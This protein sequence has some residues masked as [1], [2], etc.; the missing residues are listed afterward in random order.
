METEPQLRPKLLQPIQPESGRTRQASG[1]IPDGCV[2]CLDS[3][4]EQAV[5]LP[6]KHCSFDFLCLV[7]WLEERSVC[8]LC[9]TEVRAIN[10]GWSSSYGCKTYRLPRSARRAA[11]T[12]PRG[13]ERSRTVSN[14]GRP[15]HPNQRLRSHAR[16]LP[17]PKSGAPLLNRRRIYARGLYSLHVGTNRLSRY[18]D[19]NPQLFQ[20]DEQL[21]RRARNWIRR[22]LQVFDFL[23][24]DSEVEEGISRRTN[25]AEFLLEYIVAILKTVDLKGSSG[26]AEEMLQEFL[27]RNNTRLFLHELK[28]WLRSPYASLEQW[29]RH[30]QYADT[31]VSPD[32]S[33]NGPTEHYYY[34]RSSSCSTSAGNTARIATPSCSSNIKRLVHDHYE[35]YPTSKVQASQRPSSQ[36]HDPG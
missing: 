11:A 24:N 6:C 26:Q 31:A 20:R 3:I 23:N 8:P 4:S 2:I 15:R 10:Y 5:T 33:S 13:P 18:Q 12:E 1:E 35:P 9:Q 14:G 30:V 22:E 27:G 28:A 17:I 36:N 25:N 34:D 19:L 21:V 7:S 29:D 16:P 32:S